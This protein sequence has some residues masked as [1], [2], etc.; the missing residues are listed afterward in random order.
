M[1]KLL[2]FLLTF[3]MLLSVCVCVHAEGFY[4]LPKEHWAYSNIMT[5]VN[6]GTVNGYED[7]SF[8]PSKTVT[9]AEFVKMLGKWDRAYQGSF[10]DMASEHWAYEY[11][12]WS[13]LEPV[14]GRIYPDVAM[15]RSDVINLI[16]KRNGSPKHNG[17]PGAISNQGTNK[18]A[19]SWAYTIG[20]VQGDDGFNLHLDRP[21][22]RAEAAT[23]IVRSKTV[24]SENKTYNFIDVVKE[25]MLK[26]V[27][28][29][30]DIFPGKV[31]DADAKITYGEL[32][33]AAMQLGAFGKRITYDSSSI[34]TLDVFKHEYTK[35]F[36]ILSHKVW[37]PE[38]YTESMIDKNVTVQDALSG[39]IYGLVR[40]GARTVNLGV[41]NKFY[42]DLKKADSTTMENLCLSYA[43][44]NGIKLL[45]GDKLNAQKEI[46][47]REIE[48][49]LLQINAFVGLEIGYDD[50]AKYNV[51]IR[52]DLSNYPANYQDYRSVLDDVPNALYNLK[53]ASTKA[54]S[55]YKMANEFSFVYTT[56]LKSVENT[57]KSN[58]KISADFKLYPSLTYQENNRVVFVAECKLNMENEVSLDSV[59]AKFLKQNTGLTAKP[60]QVFYVVFETYEPLMD[61][62]LPTSGAYLKTIIM[63]S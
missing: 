52:T 4:D 24:V 55:F 17:A 27:Y 42:S 23:L 7:G 33:R 1:K 38:Y 15:L 9:R 57:I 43:Y 12:K 11:I 22:T 29:V 32:S 47:V 26:E 63:P 8:L 35:D 62:Y 46:T 31:Y 51:M 14:N 34:D 56:Y 45:A 39:L 44:Q 25:D 30:T 41:M 54:S 53:E 2:S 18:D 19:T 36:Y 59:F 40:R 16:W 5:L 20:L 13:G 49:L 6:E 37:G 58:H 21:L 28:R 48:A 3:I 10:S 60:S 50:N 61:I